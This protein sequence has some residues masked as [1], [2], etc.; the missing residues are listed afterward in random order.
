MLKSLI[1]NTLIYLFNYIKHLFSYKNSQ[2]SPRSFLCNVKLGKNNV[3]CGGN[4][5]HNCEIGDY[6]Y[7]SG[8]EGGGI[9]SGYQNVKIGKYCSISTKIEVITTSSHHKEFVSTFPFFSMPNSFCFDKKKILGFVD[10]RP[11]TIGNDVWIGA[12]ATILGGVNI[13]DGAIIGAGSVVTKNVDPYSIVAGTP[14]KFIGQRFSDDIIEKLLS[15]N[16]WDW[17]EEK[18]RENIEIIMS[19]NVEKLFKINEG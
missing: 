6:T 15:L 8:T 5:L 7:I 3:I 9:V 14:A 17:P 4:Y 19:N 16:W 1:P 18:I 13:G 12:G 2:V 10:I 11:V